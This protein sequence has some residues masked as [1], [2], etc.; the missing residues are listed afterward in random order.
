[1]FSLSKRFRAYVYPFEQKLLVKEENEKLLKCL[2]NDKE[3]VIAGLKEKV[4]KIAVLQKENNERIAALH[5]E[6]DDLQTR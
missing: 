2:L 5:R 1:M 6:K 3:D 4:G